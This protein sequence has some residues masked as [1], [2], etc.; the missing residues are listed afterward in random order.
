MS[1]VK[2]NTFQ[3]ASG[4]S[5]AVLQGVASP[6]NSMGF[7]NRII[8]GDMRIDQRNAGASVT[9]TNGSYTLDRWQVAASQASKFSIQRDTTA[10]AEPQPRSAVLNPS[11]TCR[12]SNRSVDSTEYADEE[13][14]PR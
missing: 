8:N 9:P 6:P 14:T 7:R 3:D 12:I 10:P 2:A 5:N 13:V 4:G 11:M 1:T